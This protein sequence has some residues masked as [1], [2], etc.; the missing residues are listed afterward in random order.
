MIVFSHFVM[1]EVMISYAMLCDADA[2]PCSNCVSFAHTA[3]A[4]KARRFEE[5][6][7]VMARENEATKNDMMLCGSS[8]TF[9]LERFPVSSAPSSSNGDLLQCIRF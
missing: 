9:P 1:L 3:A 5:R 8:S 6:S 4:R 7:D 2:M